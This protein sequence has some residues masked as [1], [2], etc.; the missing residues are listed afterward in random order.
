MSE[1]PYPPG[2]RVRPRQV[3]LVAIMMGVFG[4]LGL[5]SSLILW[6]LLADQ[7]G[8]STPGWLYLLVTAQVIISAARSSAAS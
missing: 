3:T 5:A 6:G 4:A 7:S 8:S 1:T 2:P